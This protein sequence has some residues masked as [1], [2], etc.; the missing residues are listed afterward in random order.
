M[1]RTKKLES[2]DSI[3]TKLKSRQAKLI[4]DYR[5]QNSGY[6]GGGICIY[7]QGSMKALSEVMEMLCILIW[8]AVTKGINIGGKIMKLRP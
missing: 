6:L 3:Y 7:W 1:L 8:E 5:S 4:Y 2:K